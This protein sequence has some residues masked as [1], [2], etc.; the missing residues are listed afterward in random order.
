MWATWNI[1]CKGI[2]LNPNKKKGQNPYTKKT[3]WIPE[4]DMPQVGNI[5]RG[6][7]II[8][9]TSKRGIGNVVC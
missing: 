1:K 5:W 7:E 8:E 9:V 4:E 3:L 2:R 6:W